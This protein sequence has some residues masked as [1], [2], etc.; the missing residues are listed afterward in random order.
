MS[1]Y[2]D[3]LEQCLY[4][5]ADITTIKNAEIDLKNNNISITNIAEDS[6]DEDVVHIYS[7]AKGDRYPNHTHVAINTRKGQIVFC[8]CDCTYGYH[9]DIM[10]KHVAGDILMYINES[11]RVEEEEKIL[12]DNMGINLIN[13]IKNSKELKEKVKLEVFVDKYKNSNTYDI[14]FKIGNNRMYVLKSLED[15]V[16]ARLNNMDLEFGKGFT[17][18]PSKQEFSKS[19]EDICR[20]IEEVVLMAV[21][22]NYRDSIVKGKHMYISDIG[23]RKFLEMNIGR[24]ITLNDEKFRVVNED[25]PIKFKLDKSSDKFILKVVDKNIFSLTPR[26]DVYLFNGNIYLPSEKQVKTLNPIFKFISTYNSVQF[27]E[28]NATELFNNVVSGIESCG[29]EV[30][31]DKKIDNIINDQLNAE[32]RLDY[33]KKKMVLNVDL[34]YGEEVL[35][36]YHQSDKEKIIM[37]D[38]NKEQDILDLLNQ[39]NFEYIS[40]EFVFK[41]NEEGFYNFLKE[42]YKKLESFGDVYYSDRLKEKKVYIKPTITAGINTNDNDY[43]EF[44]F[45]IEDINPSEYKNILEALNEKRKYYKL[46]DDSFLSLENEELRSFLMLVDSMDNKNKTGKIH[47]GRN[48]S[49]ILNSYIKDKKL[50]F[51]KGT[52]II[53]D[54]SKKLSNLKKLK[55]KVPNNLNAELRKYQVTGFNWFKNLSYLGFGGILADEM[56]LGKTIQTIAFLLSE[57][58]KKTLIITPTSLIYNWKNEFHKFAPSMKIGIVHGSKN[59]RIEVLKN[60]KE[61][62][63]IL[64]TYGTLRNDEEEYKSIKFD[65]CILDEGQNIKNPLAQSTTSVKNINAENRFVLTG[66]PI[67]NNLIELWSIFDFLMPG[68]LDSA[69]N[70]KNRFV[71]KNHS[72][73]ELQKYIKPFMLRRLK[74]DVI[75]ELPNKIE[76][77]Y[78]VELS[79]DQKKLYAA[80]VEEIKE[81]MNSEEFKDDK[82]TI[83]SYLTKLRQLCL[84]PSVIYDNYKGKNSKSDELISIL[85]DYIADNHKILVFSQFTSVLKNISNRLDKEKISHMYLDGSIN[86]SK[87]L[88]L[89]KDFNE[90]KNINVFLI[91]LKAG[92]TGL[93]LTSADVVIHFDPWWNPAVEEQATDRAHRIGQKNVVQV[94]KLISEGTIED[95]I[96]NM[97]EEK[98]KMI[99]DVIDSSYTSENILKSLSSD[100]LKALFEL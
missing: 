53:E 96:I 37:R 42:D 40:G 2:L 68:Y 59:D 76:K 55:F 16:S 63:V 100:E 75:K 15:F 66:T 50:D 81:K 38:N 89:V 35:K 67:E 44:N 9:T 71:N 8:T 82:I 88:Q 92:G 36:F 6:E 32:F 85:H 21:R 83:F 90:N 5:A 20:Y 19:D 73:I 43:L 72:A 41:G 49:F 11:R 7:I 87:R 93:N 25:I 79:K 48:K 3:R 1:F 54:I 61:Y 39:L 64:T 18:S 94:I 46:K 31:L 74:K 24:D 56:G 26:D 13:E 22:T 23:L 28:E 80:Y 12:Y 33:K 99:N 10:C 51:I 4:K 70:F 62:D 30:I 69:H 34:K 65:Y 47:I 95:K 17:Y 57:K 84:D 58:N 45:Q 91:S 14:S 77:N 52:E 29:N 97:Q 98:K 60:F 27:K 78:Y 86:A